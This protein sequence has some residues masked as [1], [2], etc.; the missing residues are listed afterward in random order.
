MKPRKRKQ[1]K[2]L[3]APRWLQRLFFEAFGEFSEKLSSPEIF[4]ISDGE[5]LGHKGC[6]V[7]V[8]PLSPPLWKLWELNYKKEL[9]RSHARR[10][11]AK[12]R[13]AQH[14]RLP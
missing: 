1:P 6:D 11:A 5:A 4:Y 14:G 8:T 3:N 13:K 9:K 2:L 12:K 10:K 7:F